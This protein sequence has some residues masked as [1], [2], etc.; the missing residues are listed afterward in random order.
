MLR[1]LYRMAVRF[2]RWLYR[3]GK[4]VTVSGRETEYGF[5][6]VLTFTVKN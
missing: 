1:F 5:Q 4:K 2:F 6:I 3:W